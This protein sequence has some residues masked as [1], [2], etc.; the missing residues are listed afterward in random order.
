V[1][2]MDAAKAV[3]AE[4]TFAC[5]TATVTYAEQVYHTVLIG[6]QCWLKENLNV[7]TLINGL[8][9]Q[10]TSCSSIQKWCWANNES[11]CGGGYGGFYQWNQVMC[12]SITPGVQG[13][14][15]GGWHIPTDN[16][17]Y[18]LENYLK[19]P[20]QTCDPNRSSWDCSSTGAKLKSGGSSGFEAFF[21]GYCWYGSCSYRDAQAFLWSSSQDV[22]YAR[23][24]HLDVGYD[25]IERSS[26]DKR[27]GY[28]VRCLKD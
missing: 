17:W 24:R 9:D 15:P 25:T 3:N 22:S 26:Q 13:I 23:I 2:S 27:A 11:Y 6:S 16:E 19:D 4:F 10:G 8:Y 12:G 28:S 7:G 14:C 21:P 18:T 1:V 20:G 5:G